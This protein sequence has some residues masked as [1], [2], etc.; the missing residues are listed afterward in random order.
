M[1]L[2]REGGLPDAGLAQHQHRGVGGS[3]ALQQ[4]D[5]LAHDAALHDQLANGR[6]VVARLMMTPE[7]LGEPP[8]EQRVLILQQPEIGQVARAADHTDQLA[9]GIHRKRFGDYLTPGAGAL[10]DLRRLTGT[11]DL[12]RHRGR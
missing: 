12:E 9:V 6:V 11:D 1:Q 2:A 8:L 4:V 7:M 5:H 10:H 3:A